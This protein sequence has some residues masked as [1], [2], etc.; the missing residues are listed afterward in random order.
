MYLSLLLSLRVFIFRDRYYRLNRYCSV[1]R[2]FWWNSSE[3]THKS[4]YTHNKK[5]P[6]GAFDYC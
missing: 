4:I 3:P 6:E 5:A 2:V 1:G